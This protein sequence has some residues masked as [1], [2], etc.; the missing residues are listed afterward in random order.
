V[1]DTQLKFVFIKTP[2]IK[3]RFTSHN[4]QNIFPVM[5]QE[6]YYAKREGEN[7]E[8]F[9]KTY[10]GTVH[11]DGFNLAIREGYISVVID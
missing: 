3:H 2:Q 6:I 1:P 8:F 4:K 9:G 7:Y 10:S 5:R 11:I